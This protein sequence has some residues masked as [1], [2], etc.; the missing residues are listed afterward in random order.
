MDT[1]LLASQSQPRREL[2]RQAGIKFKTIGHTSDEK[3]NLAGLDFFAYVLAIAQDKMSHVLL[4]EHSQETGEYVFVLTADSLSRTI[5]SNNIFGKPKDKEDA[6]R[7]MRIIR[8]EPVEIATGCCLEKKVW[9]N[10]AWHTEQSEEWVTE[11][12][13]EFCVEEAWLETYFEKEPD[14]LYSAGAGIIENY[15][16]NFFKSIK[17]S[18][19][20]VIGLPIFELRQALKTLGFRFFV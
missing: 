6:K 16:Q 4:P 2:L 13:L 17:G 3:V 15:G 19:T 7:M 9:K 14:A 18:Y 5:K 12:V 10:N 8:E 11:G 1:L 20:A